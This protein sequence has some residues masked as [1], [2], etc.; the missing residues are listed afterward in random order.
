V[1]RRKAGFDKGKLRN[2]IEEPLTENDV[3]FTVD[4]T[5]KS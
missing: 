4:L 5:N 3:K 2:Q 1:A